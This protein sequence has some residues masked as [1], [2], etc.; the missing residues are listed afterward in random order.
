MV[1][2]DISNDLR[3]VKLPLRICQ[4]VAHSDY[5]GGCVAGKTLA[6]LVDLIYMLREDHFVQILGLNFPY[7]EIF[8]YTNDLAYV[9]GFGTKTEAGI[10]DF[11]LKLISGILG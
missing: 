2:C 1:E 9:I 11:H 10:V 7:K 3:A 4:I 6:A 5:R 8:S